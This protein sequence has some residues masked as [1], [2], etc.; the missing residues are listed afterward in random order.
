M[1]IHEFTKK[2]HL[3]YDGFSDG[4][5]DAQRLVG[6]QLVVENIPTELDGIRRNFRWKRLV[7]ETVGQLCDAERQGNSNGISRW[8]SR[9]I[10][11]A[12]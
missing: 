4:K 12:L 11:P 2:I 1:C 10:S 8:K 6:I 3:I 5:Y 9:R 7:V